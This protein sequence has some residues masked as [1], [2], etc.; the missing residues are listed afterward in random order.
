MSTTP[1]LVL[2]DAEHAI[3]S[4]LRG[5][6]L[7]GASRKVFFGIPK[8]PPAVPYPL[9]VLGRVGGSPIDEIDHD[10]AEMQFDVLARAKREAALISAALVACVRGLRMGDRLGDDAVTSGGRIIFGPLWRP[11]DDRDLSRY[12]IGARFV[13]RARSV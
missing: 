2:P 6:D 13:L 1:A 10:D 9:V 12:V 8:E 3:R 4:W 7:G 11:E 5:C